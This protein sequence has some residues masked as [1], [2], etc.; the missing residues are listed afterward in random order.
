MKQEAFTAILREL[1]LKGLIDIFSA[2]DQLALILRKQTLEVVWVSDIMADYLGIGAEEAVGRSCEQM[3]GPDGLPVCPPGVASGKVSK[4]SGT[5]RTEHLGSPSIR[6]RDLHF[7]CSDGEF[8]LITYH[9]QRNRW[10]PATNAY[11]EGKFLQNKLPILIIE[12]STGR[13]VD[14]NSMAAR[15]AAAYNADLTGKSIYDLLEI[16]KMKA[17]ELLSSAMRG[18]M[19]HAELIFSP[20]RGRRSLCDIVAM[21]IYW[22][23]KPHLQNCDYGNR[24]CR[25]CCR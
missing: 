11:K 9:R 17:V 1:D 16:E 14:V 22:G 18:E 19:R 7:L 10:H 20:A 13:I 24:G 25:G 3:S 23:S 4:A 5:P 15:M 2:F 6:R 12:I 8:L 21:P